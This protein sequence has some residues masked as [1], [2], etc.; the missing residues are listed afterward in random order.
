MKSSFGDL[1][2]KRNQNGNFLNKDLCF[3]NFIILKVYDRY[4]C[5]YFVP[6]YVCTDSVL[7]GINNKRDWCYETMICLEGC[8]N[9][10]FLTVQERCFSELEAFRQHKLIYKKLI[11]HV[12][13][14]EIIDV[15][16]REGFIN[17]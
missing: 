8:L 4:N 2:P 6:C 7:F 11:N 16:E 5:H 13:D 14:N 9:H 15:M 1:F 3:R 17:V 10:N 12:Y